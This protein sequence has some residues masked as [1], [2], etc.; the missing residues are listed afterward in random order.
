VSNDSFAKSACY[1]WVDD[2]PCVPAHD[3]LDAF[4]LLVPV[5][6][7]LWLSYPCKAKASYLYLQ[8]EVFQMREQR[9]PAKLSRILERLHD[10]D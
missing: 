2:K 6:F 5:Y 10:S 9:V 3:M 1:I 7:A 8:Q 4:L